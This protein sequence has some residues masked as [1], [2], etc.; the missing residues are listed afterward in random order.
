MKIPDG[1]YCDGCK[2]LEHYDHPLVDMMG[3]ETGN[4]RSGYRC[5]LNND[6][7]EVEDHCC[8]QKVKKSFWCKATDGERA[9]FGALWLALL[10]IWPDGNNEQNRG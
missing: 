10:L 4:R 3:N 1:D 7:L 5:R 6:E 8:F 9:A 2:F